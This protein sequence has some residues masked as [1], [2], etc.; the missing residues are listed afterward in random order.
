MVD[1]S[2]VFTSIEF[3]CQAKDPKNIEL[4]VGV[5]EL[6]LHCLSYGRPHSLWKRQAKSVMTKP[7]KVI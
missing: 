5:T 3:I 1:L 6:L 4:N 2:Q 7:A